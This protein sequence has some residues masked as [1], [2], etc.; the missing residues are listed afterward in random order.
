MIFIEPLVQAPSPSDQ[1]QHLLCL[2][3]ALS[4]KLN[5]WHS[6]TISIL[7]AMAEEHDAGL[8]QVEEEYIVWKKNTPFLYDLL[9]SHS[10]EWP[11]LTVHWLPI[12]PQ[13]HPDHPCLNVHK[14]VLGTHTSDGVP[15]LLMVADILVPSTAPESILDSNTEYPK[16]P[17]LMLL[18][19]FFCIIFVFKL[20]ISRDTSIIIVLWF[21]L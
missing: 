3:L 21:C 5:F 8:V 9:I 13:P 11:S 12:L 15:N 18:L 4:H 16:V 14:L 20:S 6:V 2:A 10:L 17:Y 1:V 19:F 7:G